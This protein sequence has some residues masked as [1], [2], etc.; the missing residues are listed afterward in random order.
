MH[1]LYKASEYA[2]DKYDF[3][4]GDPNVLKQLIYKN[5]ISTNSEYYTNRLLIEHNRDDTY[6]IHY[7]DIRIHLTK[8]EFEDM[9]N[10]FIK[11]KK[12]DDEL[13]PFKYADVEDVT[14]VTVPIDDIQPYDEGHRCLAIDSEHREGIEV[15]KKLIK[16]GKKIRPI[17]VATN[18]QR[19]DGFKRYMAQKELG[20][21][22][23]EVI[24][25][26]NGVMGGQHGASFEEE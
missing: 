19:L 14:R 7:R 24:V 18:G 25:D 22:E 13:K 3:E 9:A 12:D 17:L 16:E 21:K 2:I 4:E 8:D 10:A 26:P 23:I 11:A 20:Y 5:A 1:N 6:H 15:V